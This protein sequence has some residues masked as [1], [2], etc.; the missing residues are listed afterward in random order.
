[1][2]KIDGSIGEGGGQVLRT[3]LTMSVI[4]AEAFHIYNIRAGRKVPGLRPQHLKAVEATAEISNGKIEGAEIGSTE[5]IFKPGNINSGKF[6]FDIG[7]AGSTSL[8]LQTIFT[9]LSFSS[10]PSTITI[11]GGTHV[12][13]SPSYHYLELQWSPFI[14]RLGFQVNLTLLNAGFYPQGG[15][16]I[17]ADI[18]P[19]NSILPLRI[20][21]RGDLKQIRGVS[22]VA[23]LPRK[24]A[25]RQRNRVLQRI[26][27]KYRLSDLRIADLPS[28]FKGTILLLL[29]EFDHSQT[30]YFGL[31]AIGKPAEKV[32]DEA[33]DEMEEFLRTSGVL[34]QYLADQLLIPLAFAEE[35]S[36]FRTSKIT[37]HLLTNADII[38]YFLPVEIKIDG[39]VGEH[40]TVCVTGG[41]KSHIKI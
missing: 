6:N 24:I 17:R 4:M 8:V 25:E 36:A 20:L 22:G 19:V 26:G 13:W 38:Q 23:N 15:G 40:G 33:I 16:A 35:P 12:P 30:C 14:T 18:K 41:S 34:D 9:P 5:L 32:A 28:R 27:S 21:E 29:A 37:H 1:M 39:R 11:T 7:T 10:Q 3:S 31:G 2:I